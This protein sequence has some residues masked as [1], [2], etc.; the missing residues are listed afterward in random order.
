MRSLM[1]ETTQIAVYRQS[2]TVAIGFTVVSRPVSGF[3]SLSLLLF[4]DLSLLCFLSL[5]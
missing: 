1:Q 2:P 3:L 5:S 4:L